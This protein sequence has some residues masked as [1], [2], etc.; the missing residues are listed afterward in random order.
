MKKL[1]CEMCGSTDLM[2]DGGV[3][4]CQTCGCKYSVEEAR[5]M[6]IEG[7]VDVSGST[8]K[9]DTSAKLQNLYT[10]ARRAKDDNNV[11]DAAK[12]YHEIRLE[13]PNSWEAAFYG[14]YFT[15]LDCRIGQIE[16]AANSITNTIDT[17]SK[18]IQTHVPAE[19]QKEA[20]TECLLHAL[21]AGRVL[22]NASKSTYEDSDYSD[23]RSDFVDRACACMLTAMAA[24]I[25]AEEIFKDYALAQTIYDSV[26]EMLNTSYVTKGYVKIC[27]E[28]ID[29]LKPK[30]REI[31]KKKNEE[32]WKEHAEEKQTHDSRI[33]EINSEIKQLQAQIRQ[34]DAQIAEIK[35]DLQQHIPA[36][37]QLAELKRQQNDLINQKSKL[38]LFAGK[39]KKALQ[40]QIDSMQPQ[41]NSTEETVKR[42][43]KAI[44]DDVNARVSAVDRECKPLKDKISALER[45][46]SVITAELTKDR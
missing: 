3:F 37:S 12:Y 29:G 13:D 18:M 26:V 39:Q 42:Q 33:A 10:L 25:A 5:K 15:A 9:V 4:V 16:A 20:Y 38:G 40:E 8:I 32:Y 34:Y 23:A 21:L 2:K 27:Q 14:V 43:K 1:T 6:M 17:V 45:E 11:Q 7:T 24:G 28:R 41:I 35:K 31:Q 36:E 22:F 44:Q 46:K 19:E 30:L